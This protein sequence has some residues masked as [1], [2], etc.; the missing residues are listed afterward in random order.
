MLIIQI[1]V[2]DAQAPKTGFTGLSHIV[3]LA[4]DSARRRIGGVPDDADAKGGW[5]TWMVGRGSYQ[6]LWGDGNSTSVFNP[7]YGT[8]A[9]APA[10]AAVG[11]LVLQANK[12]LT[13]ADIE[14]ILEDTATAMN[15]SATVAGA[16]LVNAVAA[17]GAAQTLTFTASAA[18]AT[19]LGT[20]LSDTFV[21]G[22]GNHTINGEGTF[23]FLHRHLKW[24]E[25][26]AE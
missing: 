5:D 6:R 1:D 17:V 2:V 14:N 16:G 18:I 4:V 15:A 19:L 9:A 12:A 13:P 22:P 3:G 10:A 24:P 25:P 7:F 23:A 26:R 20:H 21:G 11:A 8:S